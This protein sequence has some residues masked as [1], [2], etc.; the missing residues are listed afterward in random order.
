MDGKIKNLFCILTNLNRRP[1]KTHRNRKRLIMN[2][3]FSFPAL[4]LVAGLPMVASRGT[5]ARM[6]RVRTAADFRTATAPW[7]EL[8]KNPSGLLQ[9]LKQVEADMDQMDESMAE[10]LEAMAV[11]EP[12]SMLQT[13]SPSES[14]SGEPTVAETAEPSLAPSNVMNDRIFPTAAPSESV[15]PSTK[16]SSLSTVSVEPSY[17][18]SP[19]GSLSTM[20]SSQPTFGPS[21]VPTAAPS[22]FPTDEPATAAPTR[23]PSPQ[24]SQSPSGFPSTAPTKVPSSV[25]S[26][27]P[28]PRPTG[29]PS[30]A[31]TVTA[32]ATP[33][34]GAPSPVPSVGPTVSAPPS[35]GPTL[36]DCGIT[37]EQRSIAILEVLDAVVMSQD[38]ALIIRDPTTPQGRATEWIIGRDLR[39][40]CPDNV[41]SIVQRWALAV[42]YYSTG[43]DDWF[44]CFENNTACGNFLPFLNQEAFLSPSNECEW[45]G[46]SCN[47]QACVTEI[48][49]E[50]N[51]LVGTIPT[52][53]GLFENLAI[54]GMERGGLQGTIPTEIGRL[55]DTLIFLDLDFNL[56]TG[57]LPPELF[58][59]VGLNQLDLNNNFLEGNVDGIGSLTDLEFLQ[60][61]INSFTGTIPEAVGDF[62]GLS[63]FTLHETFFTGTMP[64][65]VCTLVGNGGL[66]SLIADCEGVDADIE[67]T[68]CTDCRDT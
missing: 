7:K 5:R 34:T 49:F 68:C 45:A 60:L 64:D 37:P 41:K 58:T 12:L 54:W 38:A 56:L 22:K 67:C 44:Q 46:I 50:E 14:P 20:P 42:V 33:T 17:A 21:Q 19:L 29:A 55:S 52:E 4:Y 40:L 53:M 18:P 8:Q 13:Q 47:A 57:T 66:T 39:R 51:N 30:A 1:F 32:S 15:M 11:F 16:P 36:P 65:S 2:L 23:A 6:G 59:L 10:M 48:E 24:P 63:T 28:S 3:F 62:S 31:P 43:G 25:P 9:E 26:V 35:D 27:A 61:H